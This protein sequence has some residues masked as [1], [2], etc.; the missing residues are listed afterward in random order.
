MQCSSFFFFLKPSTQRVEE[1]YSV[2]IHITQLHLILHSNYDYHPIILCSHLLPSSGSFPRRPIRLVVSIS[3]VGVSDV[4][5]GDL[6][7]LG[8]LHARV[9]PVRRW[10]KGGLDSV[11]TRYPCVYARLS[12][13]TARDGTFQLGLLKTR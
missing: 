9:E 10:W 13:R 4:K 2:L 6:F 3:I 11:T 12:R 5:R 7:L 1:S 8:H